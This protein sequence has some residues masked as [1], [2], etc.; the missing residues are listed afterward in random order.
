MKNF[1]EYEI[2]EIRRKVSELHTK[3]YDFYDLRIDEFDS[4]DIRRWVAMTLVMRML[5]T[6]FVADDEIE[7]TIILHQLERMAEEK[8]MRFAAA[9][10]K[11]HFPGSRGRRKTANATRF[12]K[13]PVVDMQGGRG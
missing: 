1:H 12:S 2:D 9:L 11:L 4:S 10:K 5:R 8:S 3:F 7:F 6:L 13:K